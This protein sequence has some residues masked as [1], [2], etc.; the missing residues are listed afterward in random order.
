MLLYWC[1]LG[2]MGRRGLVPPSCPASASLTV[3]AGQHRRVWGPLMLAQEYLIRGGD[4]GTAPTWAAGATLQ[5]DRQEGGGGA[6]D[7]NGH[8]QRAK[9]CQ[10]GKG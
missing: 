3:P 8:V 7:A 6:Q 1:V 2:L 4:E 9:S 10:E 5:Q